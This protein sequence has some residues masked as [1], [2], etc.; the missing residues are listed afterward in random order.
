MSCWQPDRDELKFLDT[1]LNDAGILK[2]GEQVT[3]INV[4]PQGVGE[5]ERLGRKCTIRRIQ[6]RY[7]LSMPAVSQV[8]T[9]TGDSVRLL[10][11]LDK[12]ANGEGI[13][14]DTLLET[15]SLTSFLNLANTNRFVIL[16]DE[17]HDINYPGLAIDLSVPFHAVRDQIIHNFHWELELNIPMEFSGATGVIAEIRS[18]NIGMILITT[19][20]IMSINSKIRIRYT[21]N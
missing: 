11:Y 3:T 9:I 20:G 2:T 14:T 4:I 1:T 7:T 21:D 19:E 15:A 6:W 16:L 5:S 13:A 8:G 10:V 12:Q 17:L 18:N